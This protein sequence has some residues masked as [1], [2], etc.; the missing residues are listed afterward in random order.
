MI[1]RSLLGRTL[2]VTVLTVLITHLATLL[3][4]QRFYVAPLMQ[5]TIEDRA[6]HIF[7]LIA[8]LEHL[9]ASS[10]GAF[11]RDFDDRAGGVL[12]S[13]GPD[14]QQV[15]SPEESSRVFLLQN[16]LRTKYP[17]TQVWITDRSDRPIVWIPLHTSH[18]DFWYL[19]Q[20][21]GFDAGLPEKW[22]LLLTL[23]ILLGITSVY[24]AIRRINR[25]LQNLAQAA[26]RLATGNAMPF[27]IATDIPSEV[28]EVS[29]AFRTMQDAL[30]QLESNRT[31]MLA[32]V[33]HDLRTPLSR[34]RLAL[35]MLKLSERQSIDPM[36]QDLEEID[37]TI[38]QFLDFARDHP[39]YSL[40]STDLTPLLQSCRERFETR[41]IAVALEVFQPVAQVLVNERAMERVIINLLENGIRYGAPPFG[42]ILSSEGH[43]TILRIRDHGP[44]I[45]AQE[46][47][48]LLQPFTRREDSRHGPPGSGLGLA[49]VSSIVAMHQGHLS[50]GTASGGGLE[51]AIMLPIHVESGENS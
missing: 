48:H 35:E 16:Q 9:P 29:E 27:E 38:D 13:Q 50:L 8:A 40:H 2:L 32:G 20:R 30:Q 24:W 49:I 41:G 6:N 18:G 14:A 36:V 33:S 51:V 17:G 12:Q 10:R 31:I 22:A 26:H 34:L 44:G 11:I 47:N 28:R 23:V 46:V 7:S 4:F 19:T 42:M 15:H 37:R 45:P 21:Q 25:P 39:Q 1:A 43:H 5:H 3:L